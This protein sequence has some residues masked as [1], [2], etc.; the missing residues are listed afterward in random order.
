MRVLIRTTPTSVFKVISEILVILSSACRALGEEA[1]T[2]PILNVIGLTRPARAVLE[3]TN[4]RLLSESTTTRLQQRQV[5]YSLLQYLR[6]PRFNIYLFVLFNAILISF[7]SV[8]FVSA[9]FRFALFRL[10]SFRSVPFRFVLVSFRI[11][12][13][14]SYAL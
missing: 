14:P 8:G 5:I 12:S 10:V 2:I 6:I 1:I 9:W 3:L 7:V 11:L 13:G 4:S